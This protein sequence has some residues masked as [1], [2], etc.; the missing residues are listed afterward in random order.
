M[1]GISKTGTSI[2]TFKNAG[3]V[4]IPAGY[5]HAAEIDLGNCIMLL[6]SGQVPLDKEGNLVGKGDLAKQAE[7][8]FQNIKSIMEEAGGTMDSIVTTG[9]FLT[10]ITQVQKFRDVRNR[11]INPE[12]PPAS[13]LVQISKLFSDD[14]LIEIEATAVIPKSSRN[15]RTALNKT[16]SNK[17]VI[18]KINKQI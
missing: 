5:S 7:Q 18:R 12:K 3:S 4:S 15:Q 14:W 9:V 13:T 16:T 2:V 1:T 8:G 6:L 11:F 10:D 17:K